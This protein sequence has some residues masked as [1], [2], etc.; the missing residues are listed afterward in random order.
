MF[1]V[2]FGELFDGLG[3]ALFF[4]SDDAFRAEIRKIVA[5]FMV[6]ATVALFANLAE[7]ALLRIA[8]A[9]VAASRAE[10]AFA[11]LI[12]DLCGVDVLGRSAASKGGRDVAAQ[13]RQDGTGT[14]TGTGTWQGRAGQG[15]TGA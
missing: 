5:S 2:L 14:G 6:L 1:T 4:E 9:G 13:D 3:M 8:G 15:R 7:V 12:H 10:A 11:S